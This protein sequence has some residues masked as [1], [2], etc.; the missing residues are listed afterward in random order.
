MK[1]LN[2]FSLFVVC[3][4]VVSYFTSAA[5]V[6]KSLKN[7]EIKVIENPAPE[8]SVEKVWSI[9]YT[10]CETPVTVSKRNINDGAVYLVST[11]FFEVC[12]AC[13]SN[14]FGTGKIKNSWRCVPLEI[15]EAVINSDEVRKQQIITPNQ[16]ND[17]TA[18]DL[19][20]SYLPNLLNDQYAHLLN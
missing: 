7:Y 1:K 2:V 19:I 11:N 8:Q 5:N 18:L 9:N 4:F 10:N 13:K 20:A 3:C 15:N 16:V 6:Q 17:E 12:Y 14:G